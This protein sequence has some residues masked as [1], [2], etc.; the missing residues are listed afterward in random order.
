[1]VPEVTLIYENSK[2]LCDPLYAVRVPEC[3]MLTT[4]LSHAHPKVDLTGSFITIY[5]ILNMYL[6]W[7]H[8]TLGKTFSVPPNL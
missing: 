7:T 5:L 8:L 4:A 1:M 2:C 6:K 3:Q